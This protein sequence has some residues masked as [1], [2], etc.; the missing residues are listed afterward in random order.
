MCLVLCRALK[1]TWERYGEII[2]V[3]FLGHRKRTKK[4][5]L[6]NS[7][8]FFSWWSLQM[9]DGSVRNNDKHIFFSFEI[10]TL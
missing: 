4:T 2:I 9:G 6:Y 5:Y 3:L 1:A 8:I 10:Y 7:I